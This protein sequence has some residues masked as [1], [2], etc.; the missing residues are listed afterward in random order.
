M[1][2]RFAGGMR[3]YIG[4]FDRLTTPKSASSVGRMFELFLHRPLART[5]PRQSATQCPARRAE[6][7]LRYVAWACLVCIAACQTPAPAVAPAFVPTQHHGLVGVFNR[8]K[9]VVSEDG[10]LAQQGAHP[11]PLGSPNRAF[12]LLPGD[13]ATTWQLETPSLG[14]PVAGL[15]TVV[16]DLKIHAQFAGVDMN[17]TAESVVVTLTNAQDRPVQ[18]SLTL[19]WAHPETPLQWDGQSLHTGAQIR[20]RMRTPTQCVLAGEG[21]LRCPLAIAANQTSTFEMLLFHADSPAALPLS[22]PDAASVLTQAQSDWAKILQP[23]ATFSAIDAWHGQMLGASLAYLLLLRD[24]VGEFY[25]V[26]PGANDYNSFW[27][28]DSAYIHRALDTAGLHVFAEEGLRLY[29]QP[30]PPEVEAM[31][32]WGCQIAQ[33][34]DG[35]WECPDTEHDGPGQSLW[36]LTGHYLMTRDVK[37]LQQVYPQ[38]RAG[39]D[40]IVNARQQTQTPSD[41]GTSHEGLLPIGLGETLISGV[42]VL[43]HNYW[44]LL[45]LRMAQ[46]AAAALGQTDDVARYK[47]AEQELAV[48]VE[49][50][51]QA[52]FVQGYIQAA[53]ETA[54][55]LD[56]GSIAAL[57]PCEALVAQ[58]PRVTATFE[59]M[60]NNRALDQ[61]RYPNQAKIWTYITADWAQA[62]LLRGQWQRAYQL[63]QGYRGQSS[64]VLGWWEE[65]FLGSGAGTGDDPHGWAAAQYVLWL[66]SMLVHQTADGTLELLRGVPPD[67]LSPE[68]PLRAD[69][70]VLETGKLDLVEAAVQTDGKLRIQWHFSPFAAGPTSVRVYLRGRVLASAAC[71]TAATVASDSFTVSGNSGDCVVVLHE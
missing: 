14:L 26:K 43:Y 2:S 34:Q 51:V 70:F 61:Y 50:G 44:A 29:W 4:I 12:Q 68:K 56:W 63:Y 24:K 11:A 45:G 28:R 39:A 20:L 25:V 30:L 15:F 53:P 67:W 65:V 23:A 36:A 62:L 1:L 10:S 48:S 19:G 9:A 6:F 59:N 22:L 27:Y 49:R 3:E 60:W 46:I 66:R 37:W 31:Q 69:H 64:P 8:S 42:H 55:T 40:W 5:M 33:H 41:K 18:T 13:V 52:A 16:G 17:P 21:Q 7:A 71:A 32:T 35:R 58:D 57:F 38:L 54:D 47:L